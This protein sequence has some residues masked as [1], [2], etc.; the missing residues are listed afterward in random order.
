MSVV[1]V[2]RGM[3]CLPLVAE[4][5]YHMVM[6]VSQCIISHVHAAQMLQHGSC[7]VNSETHNV[8]G[9]GLTGQHPKDTQFLCMHTFLFQS[10]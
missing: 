8:Y 1:S 10:A 6:L 4:K 5:D 9:R 2:C 7:H 3:S